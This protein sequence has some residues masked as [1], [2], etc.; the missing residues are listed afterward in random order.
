MQDLA[1]GTS[2]RKRL[3]LRALLLLQSKGNEYHYKTPLD[4]YWI[5]LPICKCRGV[6]GEVRFVKIRLVVDFVRESLPG[7]K[8]QTST[9]ETCDGRYR[10]KKHLG[11]RIR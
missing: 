8:F 6:C 1:T 10:Q 7:R 2:W 3:R 5:P 9:S 11:I 4:T